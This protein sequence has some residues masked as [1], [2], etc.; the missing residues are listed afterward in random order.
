MRLLRSLFQ[1]SSLSLTV[2]TLILCLIFPRRVNSA[3]LPVVVYTTVEEPPVYVTV[4]S[5]TESTT[6][7]V[8]G[9]VTITQVVTA[10]N[11]IV[12]LSPLT[13]DAVTVTDVATES[14]AIKTLVA[15]VIETVAPVTVTETAASSTA[16]LAGFSSSTVIE[17]TTTSIEATS[18]STTGVIIDSTTLLP[19]GSAETSFVSFATDV[20][21]ATIVSLTASDSTTTDV[22]FADYTSSILP[23]TT[24]I[25]STDIYTSEAA[26][27]VQTSSSD[28]Y[29]AP[30]ST[31]W[32]IS[33]A[34]DGKFPEPTSETLVIS[35]SDFIST[36]IQ[37]ESAS[38]IATTEVSPITTSASSLLSSSSAEVLSKSSTSLVPIVASFSPSSL[39]SSSSLTVPSSEIFYTTPVPLSSEISSSSSESSYVSSAPTV[40]TVPSTWLSSTSTAESTTESTTTLFSTITVTLTWSWTTFTT[41]FIPASTSAIEQS[42]SVTSAHELAPTT[43]VTNINDQSSFISVQVA[44]STFIENTPTA[45]ST[46][47]IV[48]T[49]LGSAETSAS[50]TTPAAT[51]TEPVIQTFS[52]TATSSSSPSTSSSSG[53]VSSIIP[54]ALTYSPYNNDGTCKDADQVLA[55]I[56]IIAGKGISTVRIYG[57]D[58]DSINTVQPAIQQY[59][60]KVIQ[61]FW[62]DSTGSSS[63]DDGVAS[64][65]SWGQT[66]TNWNSVYLIIVGNEAVQDNYITADELISKITS[67]RSQLRQAG[68]TGPITTSESTATYISYP[69]ICQSGSID[70]VGINSHAYFD[71]YSSAETAG[72]FNNGQIQVTKNACGDRD[73]FITET[74]YPSAGI[75]NGGNIPSK[76]NQKIAIQNILEASNGNVTL[77]TMYDDLW[78]DLGPYGVEQS[79]GI[80]DLLS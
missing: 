45:S 33:S 59:N 55:D 44:S 60:L 24:Y 66:G 42:A 39:L 41:N 12:T 8:V 10:T 64:V 27:V 52:A 9:T 48:T 37:S 1:A 5:C 53:A 17:P 15:T 31:Y 7:V 49:S 16:L 70:L 32:T 2:A 14:A 69:Q 72:S 62:F 36:S 4:T 76:E 29:V 63:I 40:T 68:Y 67:V 50:V 43:L 11:T 35:T 26:P 23:A 56:A 38:N 21:S 18:V 74:G 57:T 77:F 51:S 65:I 61:G 79:F 71:V 22:P 73:V 80:I 25:A 54:R 19:D 46:F 20:A 30:A 78:K 13:P 47:K 3:A 6:E 28:S 75:T 58:C 34:T